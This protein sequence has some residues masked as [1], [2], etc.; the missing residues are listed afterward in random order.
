MIVASRLTKIFGATTAIEDVS[1]D[2]GAGEIVGFLGPNGAGK[3]TT[4][5]V[6][7]GIFPPTSGSATI[8]GHDILDDPMGARRSLGYFPE[9]APFYPDLSVDAYLHFVGRL[10]R[11]G[12]ARRREGVERV[13]GQCGLGDVRRRL[14]GNLSKGYRQRVGLAQ[15]LLG[16]PAVLI[17]DEP[18]IG[19]DPEQVVAIRGVIA[20]LARERTVLFSSHILSEV[21]AMCSRVIVLNRGRV[22]GAGTPA[23]LTATLGARHR[24]V[25]AAD[26]PQ[27][28]VLETLSRLEGVAAVRPGPEPGSVTA[29]VRDGEAGRRAV[30]RALQARGWAI[31]ELRHDA[32][33]LEEIF[34]RLV[35][36]ERSEE[37]EGPRS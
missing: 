30:A 6:L 33:P 36:P 24:V 17:L 18:T 16:D 31:L 3:T 9:Y 13:L 8:A 22:V 7:A 10:K 1:F 29:E 35:R 34:L 14:I 20:T 27:T 37:N 5:R 15:A 26:A 11:L 4:M 21:E 12:R 19:L 32:L 28:A 23:A 2:I 25:V